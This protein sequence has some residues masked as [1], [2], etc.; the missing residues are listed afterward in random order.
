MRQGIPALLIAL[1]PCLMAAPVLAEEV[2]SSVLAIDDALF[3][4]HTELQNATDATKLQKAAVDNQQSELNR[5]TQQAKA[6][7]TA[8]KNAKTNLERDYQK[9]IDEPDLDIQPSQNAYQAAWAE[10]KQ[11]Q[12]ARLD[13]EQK[14]QEMQTALAQYQAQQ[15][16]IEQSIALLQQ[17]KMRARVDR[18]R[19][20]LQRVGEQKV[21]FTNV[22]NADMTFAQCSKQTN[23]LALQKAVNQFQLWLVDESSESNVIKPQL[24]NVSLN[25]HVLKHAVLDS[26]FYDGM[27][28]RS[29]V[30]AQLEAPVV[31]ISQND[32]KAYARWLSKQTGFKYRLPTEEEWEIAARAGSK[33][34]YWWGK[35]FGA[36][37][38]NTGWGGTTWSNKST[39]PVKAFAPNALGFYDM[40]GNVWEWTGDSRGLAKGG[41]WSFSP[42]MAKA[43][44][45]LFV[46]PT[47]A[48]NYVGFRVL[49]EL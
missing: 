24:N 35:K 19:E 47:T 9:M 2:A 4:K 11:N 17:D 25:I 38:A 34:D 37:K 28:F 33:A 10:V 39:S 30:N 45:E 26:G 1:S 5:L 22:C 40:V 29:I 16:T 12:V 42:E 41:A 43:Y 6:L 21:S 18:L 46:S 7:D 23:D 3:G 31:C 44:S 49:R 27:R 48:A 8:L 32:A 14:L 36:G 20:E 15:Q 13:A